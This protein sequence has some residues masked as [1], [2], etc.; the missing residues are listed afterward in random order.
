MAVLVAVNARRDDSRISMGG[1]ETLYKKRVR[2]PEL[3]YIAF[4]MA[5]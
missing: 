1:D 3:A 5:S 4:G 2:H